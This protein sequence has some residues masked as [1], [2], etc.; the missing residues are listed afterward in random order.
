VIAIT[1]VFAVVC[2]SGIEQFKSTGGDDEQ[3]YRSYL[4]GLYANHRLPS[5][6]ENVE[7]SLPP[8]V[9]A[10]GVALNWAFKPIVAGKP[11]PILQ[12]LPRLLRRLLWIALVA[13]GALL[14]MRGPP[15]SL[16]GAGMWLVAAT[17][18]WTYVNAAVDNEAWLPAVLADFVAAVA[19]VP[20][21]AWLA[22]EVWPSRRWAPALGA[23]GVTLLPPVFAGSLYFHPDPPFAALAALS[24]V[25]VVRATRK[26]P[27]WPMGIAAGVALGLAAL[28]RQS[29][30]VVALALLAGVAITARRAAMPYIAA[31]LAAMTLVAGAW[32]IHQIDVYGNPFESNL[33]RQGYM[34]DHQPLSFYVSLPPELVTRPHYYHFENKLLPRFHAYLWADWHGDYHDA[35]QDPKPH[36]RTLASVQSLLGFGGDALVLAGVA[37]FGVPALWRRRNAALGVLASLFVL[38]WAAYVFELIR[39]PQKG[40]DPI[41]AHYL[42]FLAPVAVVFAIASGASMARRGGWRRALL[43]SWVCAYTVSWAL[44]LATAF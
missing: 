43:Y 17:L 31:T 7:F 14:L 35:W 37:F 12:G 38:A 29:A 30:I 33:D 39:F 42:L 34:L 9:P 10:I 5:R 18:A 41:K 15:L 23:F 11:S 8:G 28:A 20:L 16:I 4:D 32:W 6:N 36:A 22:H 24:T 26:G 19:L 40:G 13:G 2:W 3:S 27:T 25:L 44:T 21:T 1:A